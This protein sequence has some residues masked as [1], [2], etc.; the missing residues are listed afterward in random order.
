MQA[1]VPLG[2]KKSPLR[3]L[4]PHLHPLIVDKKGM[5]DKR[6]ESLCNTKQTHT[7]DYKKLI[8]KKGYSLVPS[9]CKNQIDKKPLTASQHTNA[10]NYL[11]V[12]CQIYAKD[13]TVPKATHL[14]GT[15]FA[16]HDTLTPTC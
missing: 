4:L 6:N 15:E 13:M 9:S 16:V 1:S 8:N 10:T 5:T 2:C 14:L 12:S 3:H 11:T 7:A